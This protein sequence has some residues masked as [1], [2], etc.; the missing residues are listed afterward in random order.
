[1]LSWLGTV[2]P[3]GSDLYVPE[4]VESY[5]V[6]RTLS[7]GWSGS[8]KRAVCP[9]DTYEVGLTESESGREYDVAGE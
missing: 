3:V 7:S 2:F 9:R 5:K 6:T 4:E 8:W 1:M